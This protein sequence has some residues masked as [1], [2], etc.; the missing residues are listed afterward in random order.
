MAIAVE[1][2]LHD[3]GYRLLGDDDSIA[4]LLIDILRTKNARYLK[5]IPF[6]I[7]KYS[8][9]TVAI[10]KKLERN[11]EELFGIILNFTAR[12][13]KELHIKK[14]IESFSREFKSDGQKLGFAYD[15]FKEEF[16]L[17]LR[18]DTKPALLIDTQRID[19]ERTLQFGLSQ[20]FTKKE[21]QIIKR[22]QEEK[23][24]SKT[25]Y[26]YYSRKT[27]KK[28]R[29][30]IGLHDFARNIY[31]KTPKYD[32]ELYDLKKS[33]EEW[34]ATEKKIEGSIAAYHVVGDE[35]IIFL[36]NE[37]DETSQHVLKLKTIHDT[38]IVRGLEKYK[39]QDFR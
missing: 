10:R 32:E 36:M 31:S 5:A 11:E 18:N 30:I 2:R 39:E 17:Q 37:L 13:F 27:K 34:M 33:L 6:L 35:I 14:N 29:S 7:Y 20:L 19:E 3:A 24:I 38:K 22:L 28:L 25:D 9:D 26:E 1:K 23:P 15:K 8:P 4:R 16:E 12:L 21:K